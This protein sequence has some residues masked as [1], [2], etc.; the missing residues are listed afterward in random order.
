MLRRIHRGEIG[1]WKN[2]DEAC[3]MNGSDVH[4]SMPGVVGLAK[5]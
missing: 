4:W 1:A 3:R 5:N 2:T